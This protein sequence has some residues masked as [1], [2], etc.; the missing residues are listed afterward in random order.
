MSYTE[1]V[2]YHLESIVPCGIV[3]SRDICHH[4]IFG[5]SMILEEGYHRYYTGRR[6]VYGE[7][8]FPNRELL[9]ESGHARE[10]VLAIF[11]KACSFFLVLVGWIYNWC[12]QLATGWIQQ[13][14]Q[15]LHSLLAPVTHVA[16]VHAACWDDHPERRHPLLEP[17][18]R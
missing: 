6:Y 10:E 8:V 13:S 9:N 3:H 16:V 4:C 7:L 1:Q 2:I 15:R 17:L 11:V 5:G 18:S 14:A 12:M